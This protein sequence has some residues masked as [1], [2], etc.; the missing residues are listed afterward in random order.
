VVNSLKRKKPLGIKDSI[1][2][3]ILFE[4]IE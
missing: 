1:Y 3:H 2:D 4:N